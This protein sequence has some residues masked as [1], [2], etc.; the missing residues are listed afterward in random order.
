MNEYILALLKCKNI[1]NVKVLNYI[2]KNKKDINSIKKNLNDI[3]SENDLDNFE[4]YLE[5]AKNE[6]IK[7]KNNGINII[8]MF[9]NNYPRKLTDIKD[10]IL[11]LYYKGNISLIN[12]NSVAIIGSRKIDET[13][14]NITKE[15]SDKISKNGITVISGL[16]IGIDTYAHTASYNNLGKTIAVMPC[17]LNNIV[18]KANERLA[19]EI[20]NNGGL[21][22]SEYSY[23]V[24]ATQYTFVKRDRIQAALADAVLVIKA[25]EKSGT[26]HAVKEAQNENKYVSQYITNNN[27]Y[28]YNTFDNTEENIT[29]IIKRIKEKHE[30]EINQKNYE[31]ESLF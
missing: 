14:E 11:Y 23:N 22:I 5:D 16:A 26:M 17:G 21:L 15:V 6:I 18:P 4:N 25:D 10:P 3:L 9:D 19:E 28:I 29:S 20:V 8:S 24:N 12:N 2:L 31:Q 13:D 30:Q 7:N 1:G 27:K